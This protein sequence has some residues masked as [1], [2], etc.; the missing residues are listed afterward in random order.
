MKKQT[1]ATRLRTLSIPLAL[2]IAVVTAAGAQTRTSGAAQPAARTFTTLHSFTGGGSDG[3]SPFASVIADSNGNLYGTTAFGGTSNCGTVFELMPMNMGGM[4][5]WMYMELYNFTCGSD[6]ANPYAGLVL[7]ASGN[8]YGTTVNGGSGTCQVFN[9]G[10]GVVYELMSM[11]GMEMQI[12]LH[13]F[14]G[15]PGDGATPFTGLVMGPA[16]T[17]YGTSFG[18]S[19]GAGTVF[20]TNATAENVMFNF[21]ASSDGEKPFTGLLMGPKGILYGTTSSGG[22][23]GGGTLFNI[24]PD[25]AMMTTLHNFGGR[26][27]GATPIFGSL[28]QDTQGSLYGTTEFGGSHNC[29]TVFELM[30][31]MGMEM[32]MVLYN[33]TCGSDGGFPSGSLHIDKAGTLYGTTSCRGCDNSSGTVFKL[34]GGTLTT[35]H[36]FTGGDD[37][38]FPLG[39]LKGSTNGTLYGTT[40]SGGSGGGGTVWSLMP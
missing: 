14:T 1:F 28:A 15:T 7:D 13:T 32:E 6:G 11:G 10:C 23:Y 21:K 29:G 27:D 19:S 5:M 2:T 26:G 16:G 33:F 4:T 18:G 40:N 38:G 35:L 8:L 9:M 36:R 39:G 22:T 37:G 20:R 24:S 30:S 12:L 25:G 3:A 17:L 31:M 34:A